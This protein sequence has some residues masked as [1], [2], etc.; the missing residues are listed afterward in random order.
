VAFL[1]VWLISTGGDA[2]HQD[3]H[4]LVDRHNRR[5]LSIPQIGLRFTQGRWVNEF[6]V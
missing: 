2:I 3:V 5:D 1:F 6:P 4:H